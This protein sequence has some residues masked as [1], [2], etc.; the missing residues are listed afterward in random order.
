MMVYGGKWGKMVKGCM[1]GKDG[2]MWYEGIWRE[3]GKE[4]QGWHG[5]KRYIGAS[6]W[7]NGGM[8]TR[9]AW[10]GRMDICGMRVYCGKGGKR[11]KGGMGGKDR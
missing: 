6:W 10:V 1:G 11:D 9:E 5:G 2:Y 8:G 4:G 7:Y 3:W